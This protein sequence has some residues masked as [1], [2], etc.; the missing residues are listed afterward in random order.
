MSKVIKEIKPTNEEKESTNN[1]GKEKEGLKENFLKKLKQI[2]SWMN[3]NGSY[4]IQG[5][6]LVYLLRLFSDAVYSLGLNNKNFDWLFF[7]DNI[8]QTTFVFSAI[9]SVMLMILTMISTSHADLY[10]MGLLIALNI[11]MLVY[12]LLFKG[13]Y[14]FIAT[15]ILDIII[16]IFFIYSKSKNKEKKE[17]RKIDV[18]SLLTI[19]VPALATIVAAFISK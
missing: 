1:E 14:W 9:L 5:I 3:D 16:G 11:L 12:L 15:Y 17:K 13:K 4:V 2:Y 7:F 18:T 19:V 8:I 10:Y 6:I